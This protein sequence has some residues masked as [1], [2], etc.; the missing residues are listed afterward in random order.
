ME[1]IRRQFLW[2]SGLAL[3]APPAG[4]I[5][6]S[7][8]HAQAGP[9]LT[10]ILRQDLEDQDHTVQETVA[11]IVE[12][13]PGTAAPWHMHPS[14]QELLHVIEGNLTVEIEGRGKTLLKEGEAAIIP[15]DRIHLARNEST[16][17]LSKALV[18]HSR[19]AKDKPLTVIK[20]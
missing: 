1:I 11:S 14:A 20:T 9:K 4:N 17:A 10:Q 18:V 2:L 19:A 15:A 13:P 6:V 12:F 16:T 3:A 5:V 7:Q 8:A